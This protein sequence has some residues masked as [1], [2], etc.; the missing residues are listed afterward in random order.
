[1]KSSLKPND[2]LTFLKVGSLMVEINRASILLK[3]KHPGHYGTIW[4]YTSLEHLPIEFK[5]KDYI[6]AYPLHI[7]TQQKFYNLI[8][9]LPK[10]LE[11]ASRFEFMG[12]K[13][14]DYVH[15]LASPGFSGKIPKLPHHIDYHP[16][17][18]SN[19]AYGF[20]GVI[21]H[22]ETNF[23]FFLHKGSVFKL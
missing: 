9:D 17:I 2:I 5:I 15:I 1:M 11:N 16:Y 4:G 13:H 14:L 8:R 22:N 12:L 19:T 3:F 18:P 20:Q 23:E 7:K 6:T 21:V 10:I